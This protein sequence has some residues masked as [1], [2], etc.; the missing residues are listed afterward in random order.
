M[1][2]N[3]TLR[4]QMTRQRNILSCLALGIKHREK[5]PPDVRNF[6]I[7]LN[8]I[9]PAAY[10][11]LNKEFSDRLP[12]QKTI[13]S[14]FANSNIEVKPGILKQCI[15]ILKL[16]V[17][18]K[19]VVGKKLIGCIL[20]DE[21][22]IRKMIHNVN[23]QMIGYETTPGIDKK[24]A[25][26]A[27][28]AIVFMFSGMNENIQLPISYHF[29]SSLTAQQKSALLNSVIREVR[30]VGVVLTNITFDGF[31]T[32]PAVCEIAGSNLNVLSVD[33]NPAFQIENDLIYN[34]LD[35]SH[36]IKLIRNNLSNKG[37]FYDAENNPIKWS[38][39]ENLFKFKQAGNF[40]LMHKIT[41]EHINWK[42]KC[43][44]VKI[45]V[46]TIS[47]ST[48][49][50]LEF[51]MKQGHSE[52]KGAGPTIKFIRQFDRL[53]DIFN[54]TIHSKDSSENPFKRR[55]SAENA[56]DIFSF[57]DEA[58]DYIKSLQIRANVGARLTPLCSSLNKT[59]FQGWIINMQSL[60][61]LY[62][63]LVVQDA[64]ITHIPTH[65]MSQDHLEQFFGA[66]RSLLGN[67]C[68]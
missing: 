27:K 13:R 67:F 53:F 28:D 60:K 5:Y 24:D 49:D 50:A 33:F 7:G 22:A 54:T 10:R 36:A 6:S 15:E 41:Q 61:A 23:G 26:L 46:E 12:A 18:E 16:K 66:I 47:T 25:K 30:S 8:N 21:M 20:F 42:N 63:K 58:I 19:A 40:D 65:T 32:N 29:I 38:Y 1:E 48:A 11:F 14:W 37:I 17:A 44:R 45:A 59:G 9:S 3:F 55:L 52:F 43:M 51:L 4:F 2:L 34:L 62:E 57:I 35:P 39:I 68:Y 31:K 64:L 56:A